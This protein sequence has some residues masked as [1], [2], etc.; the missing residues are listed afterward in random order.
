MKLK[1]SE[2]EFHPASIRT[3]DPLSE[4]IQALAR[5]IEQRGLLNKPTVVKLKGDTSGKYYISDG[6]RRLTA[7]KFLVEQKKV[8]DEIEI[9]VKEVEEEELIADQ[10]SGNFNIKK[11]ADKAY[12]DGLYKIAIKKQMT[13]EQI[14][15]FAGLSVEY[16]KKLFKT[17][18]LPETIQEEAQKLKVPMVNLIKLS[19]LAKKVDEDELK[20]LLNDAAKK[21]A[22][23]FAMQVDERINELV[24]E[25]LGVKKS[26]EFKIEPK[27]L[28]KE[29][30]KAKLDAAQ[31]AFQQ[32]PNKENE[33][34]LRVMKEIWQIDDNTVAKKKQ[35]WEEAKKRREE[36]KEER[37]KAREQ[38]KLVEQLIDMEKNGLKVTVPEELKDLYNEMKGDK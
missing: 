3:H 6:S 28:K 13:Y 35:E 36:K 12:I 11:T 18:Q 27:L 21:P 8:K 33:I 23:D 31:L 5:D 17:R 30:L 1:I 4:D 14:A 24:K 22:K 7:L 37:K 16:I 34:V 32:N 20:D 26:N 29:E 2:I 25:R 38:K 9:D 19:E 15:K 10:I